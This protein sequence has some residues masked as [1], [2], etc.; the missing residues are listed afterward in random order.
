LNTAK[1]RRREK[2]RSGKFRSGGSRLSTGCLGTGRGRRESVS[3]EGGGLR[4]I[5]GNAAT[6]SGERKKNSVRQ[7]KGIVLEEG[8]GDSDNLAVFLRG[9]ANK[10]E[11]RAKLVRDVRGKLARKIAKRRRRRK[12]ERA[13]GFGFGKKKE[14]KER[15]KNAVSR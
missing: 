5:T 12:R 10:E 15:K 1:E 7:E 4:E 3:G 6:F 2:S 9:T 11:E 14:E 8:V 13:E